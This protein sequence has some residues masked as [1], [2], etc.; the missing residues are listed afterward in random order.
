MKLDIVN[1]TRPKTWRRALL[2]QRPRKV[3]LLPSLRSEANKES[4]WHLLHRF[5]NWRLCLFVISPFYPR[6]S[7]LRRSLAKSPVGT[8]S[9]SSC[10]SA[11]LLWP[12]FYSCEAS[13][14]ISMPT[15]S[16]KSAQQIG[17]LIF[18]ATTCSYGSNF[19]VRKVFM[20]PNV[21]SLPSV[22]L[23]S[24]FQPNFWWVKNGTEFDRLNF[25]FF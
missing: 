24:P 10:Q 17:T 22:S 21:S 7:C 23:S 1:L 9:P 20:I 16:S 19:T 3:V 8:A 2:K 14:F 11:R 13:S 15:T 6:L 18:R 5:E 12:H 4:F 25:N